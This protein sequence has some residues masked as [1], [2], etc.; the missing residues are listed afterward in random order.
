MH[1]SESAILEFELWG[2]GNPKFSILTDGTVQKI[3]LAIRTTAKNCERIADEIC[4]DVSEVRAK[5]HELRALDL[6]TCIDMDGEGWLAKIPIFVQSDL[7][8]AY[9]I[10]EKYAYIEREILRKNLPVIEETYNAC[11][12]SRFHPW[13]EMS[14]IVTGALLADL[15]VIDRIPFSPPYLNEA[16]LPPLHPDGTR[17]SLIGYEKGANE[18]P[19]RKWAFYQN[20]S[21]DRDGGLARFGYYKPSERRE[22]PPARPEDLYGTPFKRVMLTLFREPLSYDRLLRKSGLDP[23]VMKGI[24]N[25]VSSLNP[26]AVEKQNGKYVLTIPVFSSDDLRRMLK[27][28]D[29]VAEQIQKEV[30]IPCREECMKAGAS[31]GLQ[32]PLPG[33]QRL[34]RDLALQYLVDD[35]FITAVPDPPVRWNWCVW[36]WEGKLSLWEEVGTIS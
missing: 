23:S 26:P 4:V 11:R 16:F 13:S 32:F 25:Y 17:W 1:D 18:S 5:L 19:K 24:L 33:W 12:I 22:T 35:G 2:S 34:L 3:L 9:E 14:L 27:C 31:V 8:I 6:I 20:L 36:G 10:G 29:R 28:A 7:E 15:S 30:I 21:R